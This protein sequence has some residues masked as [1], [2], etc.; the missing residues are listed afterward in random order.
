MAE[1]PI[2]VGI[3]HGD[4]NGI[5]YEVII[6]TLMDARMMEICTPVVY[7]SSKIATYH[8]KLV[9]GSGDLS[10][11]VI[12]QLEQMSTK[13]ANIINVID[14]DVKV[15][16]GVSNDLAG[17]MSLASL[18][19]ATEDL[20]AGKIDVL[21]TAP[22][23]KH[24]I[25]SEAFAFAGHTEYFAKKF[26][27]DNYLMLMIAENL[28]IGT[29]TTHCALSDVPKILRKGLIKT[30]LKALDT[31]LQQDFMCVKPK[32]AVLS[33]NPHAGENG[34]F[35][36]EEQSQ[37][38]P[39]MKD[40]FKQGIYTFGPFS[41]DGFFGSG[42]YTKF[43]GILAM[44]HDQ[45]MIPFKILS[46]GKGVNYTAGLPFIRTSP[47]HG[48]AYEIAGKDLASPDAFRNAI[49]CAC[50]IFRNRKQYLSYIDQ[51]KNENNT[52]L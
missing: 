40:A 36:K 3:T 37:I 42:Q 30:K 33:L 12:A 32:I 39:A 49:Y 34:M 8:R 20:A 22:I 7:G 15:N 47:A 38:I 27:S 43:D 26:N 24:N 44:Y 46:D 11:N 48:T 25:H 1:K 50:D 10:F 41:A 2:V 31:T 18:Q 19:M 4:I 52:P 28:K 13:K 5:G 23:N 9:K 21:V 6:K 35:G 29:V 16:L 51:N 17:T 45:A 14:K